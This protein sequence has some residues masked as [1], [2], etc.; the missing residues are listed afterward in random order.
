MHIHGIVQTATLIESP[1]ESG[2][3]EIVLKI[4]GVGPGQPRTIVI[5]YP[6]LLRDETL[7]PEAIGGRAFDADIE[8]DQDRRWMVSRIDFAGRVLRSSD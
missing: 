3:L 7:D 4:Q 5:P 8:H 6:L 1:P 2:N